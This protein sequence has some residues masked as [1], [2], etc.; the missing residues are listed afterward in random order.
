VHLVHDLEN[1]LDLDRRRLWSETGES[2]AEIIM[3]AVESSSTP[4]LD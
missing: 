4:R 2:P 3:Q 1:T